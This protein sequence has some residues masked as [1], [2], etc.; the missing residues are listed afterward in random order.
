LHSV[1]VPSSF[2]LFILLS[3]LKI[4]ATHLIRLFFGYKYYTRAVH[5]LLRQHKLKGPWKRYKLDFIWL[6]ISTLFL[7]T[8]KISII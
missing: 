2:N 3:L 4:P 5:K 7:S 6:D 8:Y 1:Y